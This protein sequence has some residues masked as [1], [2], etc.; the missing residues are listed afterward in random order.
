I[1]IIGQN[2][3]TNHPRMLTTLQKAAERGCRIVS[4]NPIP[5]AAL[6]RFAHP[7]DPTQILGGSTQI[8]T[9]FLPVRID[10]DAALLKGIMKELLAQER[11]QPGQ[12]FDWE[13]IREHT[14]G[15]P[16]L[17]ADLD[18]QSM[19]ELEELSGISAAQMRQAAEIAW[20]S[21][22]I[23]CCWAMG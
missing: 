15:L 14:T 6:M 7:Q 19:A 3:G 20:Q 9:L 22:R 11:R 4:I 5:E 18:A 16:E 23:I 1:F 17:I 10:G 8:S 12:V 21:R 2:P 13:F